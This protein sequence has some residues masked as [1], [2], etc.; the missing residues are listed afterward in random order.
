MHE[1]GK[2][3]RVERYGVAQLPYHPQYMDAGESFDA[4][5][6]QPLD[7]GTEPL[8]PETLAAFGTPP[9]AGS[10]VHAL[11]VTPLNSASAKKGDPV[12]AVISQ[13]LVVSDHLFLPQGSHIKGSVLQSRPARRLGR[14]GQLRIVFHQVVPPNGFQ[15]NVDASLEGVAVAKGEHLSLDSEGG[16]Q[17]TTPRTR[18]LT[19]GIAVVLATSS[20]GDHDRDAGVHGVDGGD[21]GKGAANGA[22][23]FRFLGTIVG[24]LSHSRAVTSGFGFYGAAMSVYSHFLTKGR[25]VNYP[26]DMS[27]VIGLG[28][29]DAQPSLP[30]TP[31]AHS[32]QRPIGP[33]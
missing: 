5:L 10:V 13:P 12:D 2:M 3:H 27:M 7:F 22:S 15:Q 29:R 4:D 32:E 16:A 24:A 18:Y 19:T 6:K 21:F 31:T 11:L 33:L 28:S 23:G 1:P 8:R 14:N 30:P 17:V 26:K 20:V 25:D 9:P